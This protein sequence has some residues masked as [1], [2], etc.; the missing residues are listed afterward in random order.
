MG[1]GGGTAP[2]ARRQ[3]RDQRPLAVPGQAGQRLLDLVGAAEV[4]HPLGP[5]AQLGGGLRSAQQ[6]HR[7]QGQFGAG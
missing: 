6:E 4:M 1:V 7:Q 2:A 3:V 5:R